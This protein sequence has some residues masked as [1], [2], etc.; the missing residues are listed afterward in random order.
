MTVNDTSGNRQATAATPSSGSSFLQ[1]G[2]I[3]S[4]YGLKGWVWVYALT[5]P[6]KN[7]F[8]YQPWY[9]RR[10]DRFEKVE[11]VDWRPQGKGLVAQLKGCDDRTAAEALQD[12]E[13][14]TDGN[15]LPALPAGDY[16][17]SQLVGLAV[18]TLSGHFLG[19]VDHLMETGAND[20]LVVRPADGSV[21]CEERLI[22][23]VLEHT[24]QSVDLA[25]GKLLV[26]W[27]PDY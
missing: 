19:V 12:V 27:E 14:W 3:A 26:D 8:R 15:A 10:R 7:I 1:I 25:A 4:S 13:I 6:H 18:W 22:P 16:Y 20:V 2:R 24:V 21:D 17:W 9:L 11:V 23:Y 5:D